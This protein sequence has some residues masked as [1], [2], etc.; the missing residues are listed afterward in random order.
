MRK[1]KNELEK[2]GPDATIL[3]IFRLIYLFDA[4]NGTITG[5]D[6]VVH[7]VALV[8][9]LGI[10][11]EVDSDEKDDGQRHHQENP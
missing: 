6:D 11:K 2:P 10:A 8:V 3:E 5:C 9:S 7:L 1:K 4:Y